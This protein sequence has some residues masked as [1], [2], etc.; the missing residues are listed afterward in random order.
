MLCALAVAGAVWCGETSDPGVDPGGPSIERDLTPAAREAIRAGI[1]FLVSAQNSDGSWLTDGATGRYPTAMT[2]LGGLALLAHGSTCYSGPQARNVRLAGRPMFGHGF[3]MLFLAQ[4]YGSEG[5]PALRRRI[6][7]VLER[8]VGLTARAQG[9]LGGWYYTPDATN[10]EGA[11]T[12]TQMQGLRACANAGIPVPGQTVQKALNYI[13]QSVNADGGI[14]Y[15]AAVPG[16]SRP[17]ITCAALATLHA[18]GQY[19]GEMVENALRYARDNVPLSA[20]TPAGGQHFYY[21]HFYLSQVMYFRGGQAWRDYFQAL[22]RWLAEAQDVDGSWNGE[23]IG[24]VYGTSVAL[25]ILQLPYN[26]L[27]VFQR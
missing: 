22:S 13:R 5:Q 3:A 24:K 18:L 9:E 23:Y 6:R 12:V 8:A 11:V 16:D 7:D 1:A 19:E 17:G 14:A 10:H 21:S 4:V 20:P 2:A 27:P 25:L 26:S 15:R